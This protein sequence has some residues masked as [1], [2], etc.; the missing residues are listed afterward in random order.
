M[1]ISFVA[2]FSQFKYFGSKKFYLFLTFLSL[3]FSFKFQ[4]PYLLYIFPYK[5]KMYR[6][7]STKY[8]GSKFIV[9]AGSSFLRKKLPFP[10]LG[11]LNLGRFVAGFQLLLLM[12][13]KA[14]SWGKNIWLS[15]QSLAIMDSGRSDVGIVPF[16]C[17]C[18]SSTVSGEKSFIW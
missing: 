7:T 8:G 3:I 16:H 18:N 5:F 6:K 9:V 4:Y 1:Y 12:F 14:L 17:R 10:S 15:W 11:E 13:L 2:T